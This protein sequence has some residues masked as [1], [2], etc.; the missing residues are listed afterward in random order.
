MPHPG[1]HQ[2]N[3]AEQLRSLRAV[4]EQVC[5]AEQRG[6]V[7][8]RCVHDRVLPMQV[9]VEIFSH[10][11]DCAPGVLLLDQAQAS[12]TPSCGSLF[13]GKAYRWRYWAGSRAC[14]AVGRRRLSSRGWQ[15]VRSRS[16]G[17][18]ARAVLHPVPF[19]PCLAKQSFGA[20]GVSPPESRRSCPASSPTTSGP[21]AARSSLPWR[22]RAGAADDG[23]G[24]PPLAPRQDANVAAF[25]A[26]SGGLGC[27]G[28]AARFCL[29]SGLYAGACPLLGGIDSEG[30][31]LAQ[32]ARRVEERV[33]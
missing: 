26:G 31:D 6:F 13:G 30:R 20:L 15:V 3:Y 1:G 24:R 8:G 25:R 14:P 4:A 5:G 2:T 19:V 22:W 21:S 7:R 9:S 12:S 23:G 32:Q 17:A 10:R 16:L 33:R 29:G 28:C 11:P 18:F 27:H